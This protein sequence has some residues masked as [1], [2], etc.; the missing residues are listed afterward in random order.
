MELPEH[1]Q[2]AVDEVVSFIQ[3]GELLSRTATIPERFPFPV[4]IIN[5]LDQAN[6]LISL[7]GMASLDLYYSTDDEKAVLVAAAEEQFPALKSD[8]IVS[9]RNELSVAHDRAIEL[10][11]EQRL[12]QYH[13]NEIQLQISLIIQKRCSLGVRHEHLIEEVLFRSYK[14]GGYPCGWLGEYPDGE[15]LIYSVS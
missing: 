12:P 8:E 1:C 9:Y 13:V 7:R 6:E 14:A 2:S 15:L 3:A 4:M 5:D 11:L 10:Q